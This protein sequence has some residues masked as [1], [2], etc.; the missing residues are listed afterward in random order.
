MTSFSFLIHFRGSFRED[1][2][3]LWRPLGWFSESFYEGLFK[4]FGNRSYRWSTVRLQQ[5]LQK[6]EDIGT[7]EAVPMTAAMMMNMKREDFMTKM[8]LYLDK[9]VAKGVK[10]VGLGALTAPLTTGGL[11]LAQRTDICLTNGNAFTAVMMAQAVEKIIQET[12]LQHPKVAIVGATGSVGSCLTQ[13]LAR[14]NTV[15]DFLLVSQT[16]RKLERLAAS[17]QKLNVQLQTEISTDLMTLTQAD[18][19]VVLTASNETLIL[20]KHLKINAILLDGTQPRNTAPDIL[21]QRPDVTLIDGGLVTIQNMSL[22]MG[23]L[24]L[25]DGEYYACFSETVL[26]ALEGREKHFCLGNATLEQ[27]EE[28]AQLAF[29]YRHM[30]FELAPFSAFGQPV[31]LK[32]KEH[33]LHQG[34]HLKCA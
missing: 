28:I 12:G 27:A 33:R 17:I 2:Q 3:F 7:L 29:K 20:P 19:V 6:T 31:S 22:S 18:L 4:R 30:G 1:I 25:R 14:N 8:N 21:T 10:V 24:A 32:R 13:L 16:L 9:L 34:I 15:Q 26:L 11:A 23:S 5:N